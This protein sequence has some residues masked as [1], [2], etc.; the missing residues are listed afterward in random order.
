MRVHLQATLATVIVAI[1]V[2]AAAPVRSMDSLTPGHSVLP[3]EFTMSA[4]LNETP[5]HG[6]WHRFL[7]GGNSVQ[8]YVVYP[9][10]DDKAPVL[11]ISET[12]P[13]ITDQLRAIADQMAQEGFISIVP[14]ESPEAARDYAVR[15]PAANGKSAMLQ[16]TSDG[17]AAQMNLV[18]Q[19]HQASFSLSGSAW[20]QAVTFLDTY[21]DN[22][23]RLIFLPAHSQMGHAAMMFM[24][25]QSE[26]QGRGARG[27][28]P[29][30]AGYPTGKDEKLPAGLMTA[31]STLAH[32]TI[33]FEWVDIPLGTTKLHTR[34]SYPQG[35]GKAPIVIVMHHAPGLDPWT[36]S[37][38]D[39][40]SREGFIAIL[41]DLLSGM[42][43]NGGNTPSFLF[44]DE[45]IKANGRVGTEETMRRYQA[46]RDYGMKLP[47]ANGKSASLGFCS[48]GGS[49]FMFAGEVP[50]LN[51]AV[52]YYGG[53]PDEATMAKIKAP[54]LAFAGTD[55]MRVAAGTE[56]AIEP[57]KKFGKV[58]ETH[59]YPHA[60]HSFLMYQNIGGNPEATADSWPRTIAWLNKYTKGS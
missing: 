54:V 10:R 13:A 14:A 45:I 44:E 21:T 58:Y 24:P 19:T 50:E 53:P 39:Q 5:R 33:K 32:T 57:M 35:Q 23:P 41:P 36:E 17:A 12:N 9:D 47:Q 38:A 27:A 34:V 46:A 6:E 52:V 31:K 3:T 20:P 7:A 29:A 11:V 42:G 25:V 30:P 51:A 1:T 22:H 56:G 28:A 48:G 15:L 2:T 40:L 16:L 26:R 43:P 37:V 55:D 60:T 59:I 49:S 8:A 18:V 4:I